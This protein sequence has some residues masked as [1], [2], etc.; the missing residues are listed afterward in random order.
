MHFNDTRVTLIFGSV[1]WF[2]FCLKDTCAYSIFAHSD[3]N[4]DNI[5]T[6]FVKF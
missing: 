6:E 3:K 5:T 2:S 4:K 1:D